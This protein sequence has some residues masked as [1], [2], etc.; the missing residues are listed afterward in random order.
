[1]GLTQGF[2][3]AYLGIIGIIRDTCPWHPKTVRAVDRHSLLAV[4]GPWPAA[5]EALQ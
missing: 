1:M 2:D 4:A 3:G 5:S